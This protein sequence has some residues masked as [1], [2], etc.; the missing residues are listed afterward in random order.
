[1]II[2]QLIFILELYLNLKIMQLNIHSEELEDHL[3]VLQEKY[4]KLKFSI[5]KNLKL[6][7]LAKQN[8]LKNSKEEYLEKKI[9]AMGS[10]Y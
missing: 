9:E 2:S 4:M 8:Q 10:L 7:A 3:G 6:T 1:M 5:K